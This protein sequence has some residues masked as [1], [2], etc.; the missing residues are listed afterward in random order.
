MARNL[1]E[2]ASDLNQVTTQVIAAATEGA[3][4]RDLNT[5]IHNGDEAAA[6]RI[7]STMST[8]QL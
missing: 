8:T 4:A 3:K 7:A 5:A 1:D 6:R 2:F